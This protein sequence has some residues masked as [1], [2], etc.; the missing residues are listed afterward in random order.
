MNVTVF[1]A[2]PD[3]NLV[4]LGDPV[5][6]SIKKKY[7]GNYHIRQRSHSPTLP[8]KW[9]LHHSSQALKGYFDGH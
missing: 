2:F 1:Y 3:N 8:M 6:L 4:C 5:Y 7:L 9:K